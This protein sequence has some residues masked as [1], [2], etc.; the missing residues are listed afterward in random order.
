MRVKEAE[1]ESTA[2][3]YRAQQERDEAAGHGEA[4]ATKRS[5]AEMSA[6]IASS[7]SY[8]VRVT[9]TARVVFE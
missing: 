9:V 6:K 7:S 4:A 5:T 2:G 8:I 1:A 3:M